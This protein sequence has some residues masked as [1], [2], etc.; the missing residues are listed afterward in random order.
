MPVVAL[1]HP[2][3]TREVLDILGLADRITQRLEDWRPEWF[4]P[5]P[6]T[7]ASRTVE[8]FGLDSIVA[9]YAAVIF[10]DVA[11]AQRAA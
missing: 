6:A 5:L 8:N 4:A 7:T 11:A 1:E 2:G 9:Q 3:G 10:P